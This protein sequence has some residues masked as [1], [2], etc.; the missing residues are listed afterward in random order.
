MQ[1]ASDT[2]P[3]TSPRPGV[4][5]SA[6]SSTGRHREQAETLQKPVDRP[7]SRSQTVGHSSPLAPMS[8]ADFIGGRA[9]GPRLNK[10]APQQDATDPTLFEQRYINSSTAPHP[11]F[12][13]GGIAMPGLTSQ[14]RKVD[15]P[16]SSHEF[17]TKIPA[18]STQDRSPIAK[19]LQASSNAAL[20][21]VSTDD[22]LSGKESRQPRTGTSSPA[23]KRYVQR[24]EQ[25]ASSP[26]ANKFSFFERVNT[27]TGAPNPTRATTFSPPASQS[28]SR[29]ISPHTPASPRT[30]NPDACSL[31][32][33][34]A[35]ELS[36]SPAKH[37]FPKSPTPAFTTPR[38]SAV[39]HPS[40]PAFSVKLPTF[41]A[42]TPSLPRPEASSTPKAAPLT[43]QHR[44][45]YLL[46]PKEK[47]PTPSISRLKG[48]GFVQSM[49][50]A[51][52]ALE[53]AAAGSVASSEVGRLGPAKRSSSVA[54][55][56]KPESPSPS[57]SQFAT[58]PSPTN[59]RKSWTP[60][61]AT[62]SEQQKNV[63]QRKSWAT[64]E[65]PL[66]G[67]E[68]DRER[69][70]PASALEKRGVHIG[71]SAA[72]AVEAHPTGRSARAVVE[73]Q[74]TG[75]PSKV[76][77]PQ[78]VRKAPS[79]PSLSTP[80]RPSTPPPASPGGHG[81]GSSS[82]M[83][84]YIK[85]TKTGDDPATGPSRPHARPTTPRSR[86]SAAG[87][88]S[89]QDV[90]ELGH[91]TGMSSGGHGGRN[92]VAGFPAPSGRPLVHVRP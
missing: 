1:V 7:S 90:D 25:A 92:G 64:S 83:F 81:L 65:E 49:V 28:L 13:R 60:T 73:R 76:L 57:T 17:N 11:V 32:P 50:K 77:E 63:A 61:A 5:E 30:A 23:L 20:I 8:L 45:P 82:T 18:E 88:A 85:P 54:D 43:P 39:A 48:R 51:S 66:K 38:K 31:P 10:H 42:S 69:E 75:Q 21:P 78:R 71:R 58:T 52:S 55:R 86:S 6:R 46:P 34:F 29:P 47:D 68:P 9:T 4:L 74:P 35:R 37:P 79:L 3:N 59:F 80:S 26:Q 41:S 27:P 87:L 62:P 70:R 36:K 33:A 16:T 12:G 53:A 84:S 44:T 56:W 19:H 15:S 89:T 40:S 22:R 72:R 14:R 2:P 67:E 24:V 91:R